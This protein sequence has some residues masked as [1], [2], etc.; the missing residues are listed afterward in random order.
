MECRLEN[1]N[2]V[3]KFVNPFDKEVSKKRMHKFSL[4]VASNEAVSKKAGRTMASKTKY[5]SKNKKIAILK[6]LK[7]G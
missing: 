7:T 4:N 6:K 5:L 3:E 2:T 1:I